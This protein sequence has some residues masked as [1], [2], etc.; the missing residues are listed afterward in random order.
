MLE[1]EIILLSSSIDRMEINEEMDFS[2]HSVGSRASLADSDVSK[3]ELSYLDQE[4]HRISCTLDDYLIY[5]H[6]QFLQFKLQQPLT[7]VK[8][9]LKYFYYGERFDILKSIHIVLNQY[10]I[11]T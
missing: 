5:L 6:L 1:E 8:T 3:A 7:L 4:N 2:L 10:R 11:N 9:Q